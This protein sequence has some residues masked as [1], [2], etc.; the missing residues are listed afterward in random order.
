MQPLSNI[1]SQALASCDYGATIHQFNHKTVISY[2]A[3]GSQEKRASFLRKH[4]LSVRDF[5]D[6]KSGQ[7]AHILLHIISR[8]NVE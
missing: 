2:L 5:I 6:L 4:Y 1:A 8:N 7:L 3:E